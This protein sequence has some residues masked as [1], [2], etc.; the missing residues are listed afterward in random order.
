[1]LQHLFTIDE[2]SDKFHRLHFRYGDESAMLLHMGRD[3]SPEVIWSLQGVAQGCVLG[4]RCCVLYFTDK[5][6]TP[7]QQSALLRQ[8]GVDDASGSR[9]KRSKSTGEV[10]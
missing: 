4:S 2:F 6:Y 9:P 7:A 5:H 10:H 1:M 8:L 3:K